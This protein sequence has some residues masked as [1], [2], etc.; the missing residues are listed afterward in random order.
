MKLAILRL[1]KVILLA[2]IYPTINYHQQSLKFNKNFHNYFIFFK[3]FFYI[4]VRSCVLVLRLVSNEMV[5]SPMPLVFAYSIAMFFR[6]FLCHAIIME[7]IL[8]TIWVSN[9]ENYRSRWF[10]CTWV[11]IDVNLK[12]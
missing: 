11:I 2:F 9:Y 1:N 3:L 5:Y 4:L 7:R 12:N 10:T 8:A 6:N